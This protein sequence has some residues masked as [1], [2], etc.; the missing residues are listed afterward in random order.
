MV[1]QVTC[2]I[3]ISVQ[4]SFE[5]TF[6]KNQ[7]VYYSFSYRVTI[8]NQ[9]KDSVQLNSREWII[10]DALNNTEFV[11]G[12]GVIGQKPIIS[13]GDSHTY[14]SGCI[15]LSP[16]GAMKGFYN[17]INFTTTK[18]FKVAIPVFKLNAP[19]ALN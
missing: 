10:L 1:E 15:L 13:P 8:T 3:K 2:G 17:M 7:K 16:T 12:E 19:H 6:N 14:T 4:T 5:G 18:K 11:S 9:S